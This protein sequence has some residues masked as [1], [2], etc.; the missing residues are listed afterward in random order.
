MKFVMR[1]EPRHSKFAARLIACSKDSDESCA[2]VV[3]AS[4]LYLLA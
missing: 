1:S 3:D 4:N 2:Q